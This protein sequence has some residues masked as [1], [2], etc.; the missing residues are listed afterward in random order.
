MLPQ[1]RRHDLAYLRSGA[2]VD[3]VIMDAGVRAWIR[4]WIAKGKP[5]V[6]T[7]QDEGGDSVRL[8]AV[9]PL[10]LGRRR[11]G[12]T[13]AKSDV[14]RTTPPLSVAAVISRLPAESVHTFEALS[15]RAADLGIVVGV[16]G[17]TAWECL[18]EESY[19][20]AA[21][22]VDL[23]CDVARP[24]TLAPWLKALEC[25][26]DESVLR[27]DGEIRFPDGCCVAWRELARLGL[28]RDASVLAK[29][30]QHVTLTRIETLMESFA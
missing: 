19:R 25:A 27:I 26:S 21:S 2:E 11:V 4:E 12:C 20:H 10:R 9:L 15:K 23:V 24:S 5:L 29:G 3:P 7:R 1:L 8:G 6:V 30:L 14:A 18:A 28:G 16:Y 17:S 22:D 13:V